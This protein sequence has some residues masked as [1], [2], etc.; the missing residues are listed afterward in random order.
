M[1]HMTMICCPFS[2]SNATISFGILSFILI[3]FCLTSV[4]SLLDPL[5]I[6]FMVSWA[7]NL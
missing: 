2:S 4:I 6:K 7:F 3:V 1:T 5:F